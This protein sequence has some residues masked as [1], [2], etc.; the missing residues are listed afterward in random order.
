M[1]QK[2]G[3]KDFQIIDRSPGIGGTW[4]HNRYPGAEVDTASVIYSLSFSKFPWTRTHAQQPEILRYLEQTVDLVGLREHLRLNTEVRT[5]RWLPTET[6]WQLTFA[7]GSTETFDA[8]ICAVGFLDVPTIPDWAKKENFTGPIFHSARWPDRLNLSNKT[9]AVVGT[10]STSV[11]IVGELA[12]QCSRLLIFQRQPN[13]ILPKSVQDLHPAAQSRR[14]SGMAYH[15]HRT[16]GFVQSESGRAGG[17]MATEGTTANQRARARALAH[18]QT[19]LVGRDDLITALTPEYPFYGKR[20]VIND[21][22]Y[23]ALLRPNV[24]LIPR[25]VVGLAPHTVVDTAGQRHSVDV[26]VLA[27]GFKAADYLHDLEVT[28]DDGQTLTEVWAG[29]P[30]ALAG[31]TVSGFPNFFIMYGPNTNAGP[32]PFFLEAQA[33]FAAL[34]IRKAWR[35][36][37]RVIDTRPSVAEAY[38]RWLQRRLAKTVWGSTRSYFTAPSG[39]VVTQWPT[40]ATQ[41]WITTRLMRHLGIRTRAS[42]ASTSTAPGVCP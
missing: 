24:E 8:I 3:I 21:T 30:K 11:Q 26:V 6:G 13:W 37:R 35:S 36:E 15:W 14:A 40:G 20:P 10:G 17:K 32:V 1:L 27:T 9:V 39:R 41:Y 4:W 18:M 23:P 42:D 5:A 12:E 34:C 25:A 19:A 16:R 38:D 2:Y 7:D 28:G 31:I 22:F 33:R 29:E